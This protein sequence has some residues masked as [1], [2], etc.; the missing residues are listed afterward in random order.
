MPGPR[1]GAARRASA[2]PLRNRHAPS[3]YLLPAGTGNTASFFGQRR[4]GLGARALED[5]SCGSPDPSAFL[6]RNPVR[7]AHPIDLAWVPA[8]FRCTRKRGDRDHTRV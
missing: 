5:P 3:L 8:R 6:I 2:S 1:R 4:C 7:P